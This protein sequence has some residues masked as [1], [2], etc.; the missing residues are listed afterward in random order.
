MTRSHFSSSGSFGPLA[1]GREPGRPDPAAGGAGPRLHLHGLGHAHPATVIDN[2]FLESLDIGT[3]DAWIVSRTGIR[4]R[5]TVLPLDYLRHTRNLDPR[6]AAGAA[7]E[8]QAS[9]GARAARM[10]LERAGLALSDVGALIAGSSA[11]DTPSPAIACQVARALD[12]E[13]P[14]F[15]LASACT[16]FLAQL[17]FAAHLLPD[18]LPP[19]LLL[20]VPETIT[21]TVRYDD[22][23]A[24]VL[25]GDGAAAAVVSRVEPGR[26]EVDLTA[27]GSAPSGAELVRIPRAGHFE[28]RGSAVQRFA[29]RRTLELLDELTRHGLVRSPTLHFV[30]HQANLRMLEAVCRSARIAPERHLTNVVELGNTGAAGAPAALSA[31][32]EKLGTGAEVALAAVGAGLSFGRARLRFGRPG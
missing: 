3:D 20:V 30:G 6:E 19:F 27:F 13:V 10:A 16:S 24:A 26:A 7:E 28:Q 22:R 4:T 23:R 5:R 12:L 29:I 18:A 21:C 14:A 8:D 9:L 1:G 2:A 32:W 11:P 31:V 25:W 15:D 17:H